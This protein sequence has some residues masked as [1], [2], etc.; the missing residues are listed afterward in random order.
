M[1]FSKKDKHFFRPLGGWEVE[2]VIIIR[3]L[4]PPKPVSSVTASLEMKMVSFY[5][6]VPEDSTSTLSLLSALFDFLFSLIL[7]LPASLQADVDV[8]TPQHWS[9]RTVGGLT[10]LRRYRQRKALCFWKNPGFMAP[11]DHIYLLLSLIYWWQTQ[12]CRLWHCWP[13][14]Q[15]MTSHCSLL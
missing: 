10:R 2:D 13:W 7:R 14:N 11:I 6:S 5:G 4:N 9:D 1:Y 8:L 3:K 12:V 15:F